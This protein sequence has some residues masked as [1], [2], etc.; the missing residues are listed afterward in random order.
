MVSIV[1]DQEVGNVLRRL[2]HR[3]G[4]TQQE[5]GERAGLGRA[6]V[7]EIESGK[8]LG[9]ASVAKFAFVLGYEVHVERTYRLRRK[10]ASA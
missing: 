3:A 9:L 7:S 1:I 10:K 8:H 2:R 6:T 4:M 5:L